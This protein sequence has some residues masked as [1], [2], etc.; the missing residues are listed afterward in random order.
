MINH[1]GGLFCTIDSSTEFKEC[2]PQLRSLIIQ[3]SRLSNEGL[4]HIAQLPSVVELNTRHNMIGDAGIVHLRKC[5]QLKMVY[6]DD[7]R[8]TTD[9][10]K[11]L[12]EALPNCQVSY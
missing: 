11:T 3:D 7:T 2:F 5:N 12:Q 9:G 6:L 1:A 8:I 4:K 10:M